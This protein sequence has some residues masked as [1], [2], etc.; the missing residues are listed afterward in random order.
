MTTSQLYLG[1]ALV[2]QHLDELR[3]EAAR[4]RLVRSVRQHPAARGTS[5]RRRGRHL[6]G[7]R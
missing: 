6:A 3:H 2:D 1:G 4:A 7:D 5:G